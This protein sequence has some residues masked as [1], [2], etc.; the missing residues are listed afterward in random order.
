M[1]EEHK[2]R[3]REMIKVMQ[4]YVDGREIDVRPQGDNIDWEYMKGVSPSWNWF[5]M[6]YRIATTPDSIDW[7][8]VAPEWKYMARDHVGNV[9]LYSKKP[10]LEYSGYWGV[11]DVNS[12]RTWI[13]AFASYRRGTVDWKDSLVVRP[14]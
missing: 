3:T 9:W 4:A 14:E 1:S 6:D 13:V 8:H 10:K 2:Q 5:H 7:S 11:H 12:D